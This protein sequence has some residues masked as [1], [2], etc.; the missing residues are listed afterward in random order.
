MTHHTKYKF[1]EDS[2]SLNRNEKFIKKDAIY[3]LHL[4][5]WKMSFA[6]THTRLLLNKKKETFYSEQES[7]FREVFCLLTKGSRTWRV[8]ASEFYQLLMMLSSVLISNDCTLPFC[9]IGRNAKNRWW[10][11]RSRWA[12]VHICGFPG[13]N[14]D[15]IAT[16]FKSGKRSRG[17]GAEPKILLRP[18]ASVVGSSAC[19]VK[20]HGTLLLTTYVLHFSNKSFIRGRKVWI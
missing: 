2:S 10:G 8:H 18:Y 17:G 12:A 9:I 5:F 6:V 1:W 15:W 16:F 4:H 20:H 19:V 3:N 11:L 13:L 14:L 7:L